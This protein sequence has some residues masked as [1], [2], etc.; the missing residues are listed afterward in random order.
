MR[1]FCVL[2]VGI[3]MSASSIGL[4]QSAAGPYKI[5]ETAKVGGA[6]GFDYVYADAD[7]RR[8]Y[9]PRSGPDGRITV[10]NLDTLAPVGEIPNVNGHGAVVDPKSGH[11]FAT[12]KP[13]VMWDAKTLAPIKTIDVQGGPDGILFDPFNARVYIL[14]HGAPNM[15]AIDAATGNV[16]G[17]ID[18]GAAPEQAQSDGAGHTYVDLEDKGQVAVVDVR[19]EPGYVTAAPVVLPGT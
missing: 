1:R 3:A 2:A 4:A 18:L 10:F 17:T 16:V 15:T 7:G 14:S 11:G 13:V 19:V 12:S 8:L 9:V 6:G 5:L